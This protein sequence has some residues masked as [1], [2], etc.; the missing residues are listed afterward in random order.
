M[1][2][3]TIFLIIGENDKKQTLISKLKNKFPCFIVNSAQ[4]QESFYT[5]KTFISYNVPYIIWDH[6]CNN[7][8]TRKAIIDIVKKSNYKL[9]ALVVDTPSQNNTMGVN[10]VDYD[11]GIDEILFMN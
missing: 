8:K 10:I 1:D 7:I 4:F 5:L 11:E 6:D 3:N 9:I 2:S